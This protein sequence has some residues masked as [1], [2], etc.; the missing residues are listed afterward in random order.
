M[1]FQAPEHIVKNISVGDVVPISIILQFFFARGYPQLRPAYQVINI[2]AAS[3]CVTE[4]KNLGPSKSF[5]KF[6]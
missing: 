4:T 3:C 2:S 1:L 5:I 6:D